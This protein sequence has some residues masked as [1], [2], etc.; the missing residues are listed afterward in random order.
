MG[1]YLETD[2]EGF[3]VNPASPEKFQEEWKPVID[4]M[5]EGYKKYF[6]EHLTQVYVRGSVAKGQAVP[7]V[8]DIDTF[9]YVD[10]PKEEI[11]N[12]GR[13]EFKDEMAKRYP[14][15]EGFEFGVSPVSTFEKNQIILNQSVCVYGDPVDVKKLKP[16]KEMMLHAFALGGDWT[17]NLKDFSEKE[18]NNEK[19]KTWSVWFF[20]A[21]LRSGFEITMERSGLYT[22][23]L[24]KCYEGFSKY[25][26][27]KE[28]EMREILNLTLNPT[29]DKEKLLEAA[30]SILPWLT[31]E[32]KKYI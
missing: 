4:D 1:S 20:K 30:N 17:R 24:Y 5:V 31:E 23:D 10:L 25:Y 28:S 27:E 26:P 12:S 3:V 18:T 13:K 7:D 21:M 22:R 11:N 9:A 2:D 16:G 32:S 29:A 6:G 14:F 15:V 8:S 19:N